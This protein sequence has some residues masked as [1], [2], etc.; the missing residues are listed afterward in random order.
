MLIATTVGI[1]GMAHKS[2]HD[3]ILY[4]QEKYAIF[5]VLLQYAQLIIYNYF[6]LI[7]ITSNGGLKSWL[8]LNWISFLEN[9]KQLYIAQKI[10][11]D[12]IYSVKFKSFYIT[13]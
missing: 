4:S 8:R 5:T 6:R 11:L 2:G 3:E 1:Q 9:R 7:K 10:V 13:I 12:F